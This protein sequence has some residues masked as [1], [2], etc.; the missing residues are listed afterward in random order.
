MNLYWAG[1]ILI[2]FVLWSGFMYYEG[3]TKEYAVCSED[4]A[5]HDLAQTNVTLAAEKA[6]VSTVVKQQTITQR[7]DS[8]YEN[9]K[10]YIDSQ[11]VADYVGVQSKIPTASNSLSPLSIA[12]IRPSGATTRQLRTK[13]FKLT[14][15]QCDD[16]TEQLYALQDWV[17]DQQSIKQPSTK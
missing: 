16:N 12:P 9:T 5:K 13:V 15:Q 10:S 4:D 1:G 14:A 6:V 11:Y 2:A 7:V 8:S 17:K 3:I